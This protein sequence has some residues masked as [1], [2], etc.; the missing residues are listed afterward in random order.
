MIIETVSMT[1]NKTEH[2]GIKRICKS[3]VNVTTKYIAIY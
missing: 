2:A 3:N 1:M